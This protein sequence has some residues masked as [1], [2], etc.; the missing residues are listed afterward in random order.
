[1]TPVQRI[2]YLELRHGLFRLCVFVSC[3]ALLANFLPS[4]EKLWR[5]PR[6]QRAY[7]VFVDLVAGFGLNWRAELPSL[8]REFFGFRRKVRHGLRNWKQNR[9]DR[10]VRR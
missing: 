1:M 10:R 9:I 7:G 3:N 4:A 2:I 5:Y 6:A 8:D